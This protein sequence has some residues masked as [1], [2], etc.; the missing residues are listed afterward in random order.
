MA[1]AA[2]ES[3]PE[4]VAIGSRRALLVNGFLI[5]QLF[6]NP[7]LRLHHLVPREISRA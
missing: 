4:A 7:E 2:A 3:M 1:G 5:D 6:G